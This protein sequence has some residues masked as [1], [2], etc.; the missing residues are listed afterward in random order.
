MEMLPVSF[1]FFKINNPKFELPF[2]NLI[3][4]R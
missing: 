4:S 1:I 3:P 2:T